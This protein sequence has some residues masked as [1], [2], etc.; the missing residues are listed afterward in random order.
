[1]AYNITI[2]NVRI[3]EDEGEL[4]LAV[5][6]VTRPD[7]PAFPFDGMSA[8]TSCRSPGYSQWS[9]FCTLTG[10]TSL[11][12]DAVSGLMREHPGVFALDDSHLAAVRVARVRWE[13]AHPV[14]VPGWD[15]SPYGLPSDGP[16]D[17]VRGRDGVLARLLW[18]EWWM[19][20]A[21]RTCERP[22]IGNT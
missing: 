1:M 9:E 7:A 8:H 2:G 11:F 22:A 14:A 6:A 17:G 10:L 15:F 20:W 18:L 16:D 5:E 4:R 13:A 21:L 12:F 3:V 19:E